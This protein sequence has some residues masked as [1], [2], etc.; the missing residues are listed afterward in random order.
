[1]SVKDMWDTIRV[2]AA[3]VGGFLSQFLGGF[4][5]MVMAL[6]WFAVIDYITGI[7]AAIIEKKLDSSIGW[8]GILKK[9]VMFMIVGICHIVDA[10]VLGGGSA[11][12]T[13]AIIFYISNEGISVVENVSRAGLPV[14]NKLK[15]VLAQLKEDSEKDSTL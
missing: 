5:G 7:I 2:F 9:A 15:E 11:L 4:D 3:V 6:I 12:R 10:D 1:M 13:M 8:K 14:P